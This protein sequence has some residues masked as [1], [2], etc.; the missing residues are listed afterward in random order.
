MDKKE[1]IKRSVGALD[2][3]GFFQT[4]VGGSAVN[5]NIWDYNLK[6]FIEQSIIVTPLAEMIDFRSPGVDFKVTIDLAPSIATAQTDTAAVGVS[7]FS[8]RNLVMTPSEYG[9]RYQITKGEAVR[10][11]FNVAEKMVSKLGYSMALKKE[12][13]AISTLTASTNNIMVNSK[14][15]VTAIA[16]TDTFNT[17]L[18]LS[19]IQ[20]MKLKYYKPKYLVINPVME[21]ALFATANLYKANEFGTRDVIANGYITTL[22]GVQVFVSDVLSTGTSAKAI[23]LGETKTGE[24]AFGYAVKR[25]PAIERQYFAATRL[26]DIVGTEEYGF[27]L[28]HEDAVWTLQ[29]YAA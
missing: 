19:G 13:L 22:F 18:L 8:T 5:P 28:F 16:S 12:S 25:D 6:K 2:A 1:F 17:S 23:L 20:K 27:S 15:A 29:C 10:A 4:S 7:S 24:K 9:A 26:W 14:T 3:N 21:S 11:F